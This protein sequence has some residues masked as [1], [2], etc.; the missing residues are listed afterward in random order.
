MSQTL[1]SVT[2]SQQISA[3]LASTGLQR[4]IPVGGTNN[5][6]I[7]STVADIIHSFNITFGASDDTA[8]WNVD[9]GIITTNDNTNVTISGGSQKNDDSSVD[10]AGVTIPAINKIVAIYYEIPAQAS[11]VTATAT[12]AEVGTVKLSG[13][14]SNIKSALIVPLNK[15]ASGIDV[16]FTCGAAGTIRVVY[17]AKKT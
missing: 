2:L 17:L 10:L 4:T 3:N 8:K 9:T 7:S 15:A 14:G 6:T 1:S 5:Y 11:H 13:D 16:D 12:D